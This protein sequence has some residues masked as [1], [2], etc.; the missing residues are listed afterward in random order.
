MRTLSL[1]RASM[2]HFH[3]TSITQL[4]PNAIFCSF[5]GWEPS[6][7]ELFRKSN[8]RGEGVTPNSEGITGS[9]IGG[10]DAP[11]QRDTDTTDIKNKK[12]KT[13]RDTKSR[14]VVSFTLRSV[15]RQV[16]PTVPGFRQRHRRFAVAVAV[17]L[18]L[19]SIPVR[20]QFAGTGQFLIARHLCPFVQ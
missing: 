12:T 13:T 20:K 7:K 11:K 18:S 1:F 16:R 5:C 14:A 15:H 3:P 19:S 2:R 10:F 9:E 4:S 6:R 17:P 8:S